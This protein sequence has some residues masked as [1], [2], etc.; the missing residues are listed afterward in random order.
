MVDYMGSAICML[1]PPRLVT[2]SFTQSP[3]HRCPQHLRVVHLFGVLNGSTKR[4]EASSSRSET[5]YPVNLL[6]LQD[7]SK[8]QQQ[9]STSS[10]ARFD[11]T[12]THT[13]THT[14]AHTHTHTHHVAHILACLDEYF[15]LLYRR[16][17]IGWWTSYVR[18][19]TVSRPF[20]RPPLNRAATL[21]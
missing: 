10:D 14:H 17:T 18:G 16:K 4:F 9:E 12:N 6:T 1:L 15:S 3:L 13:H 2:E 5:V 20:S 7:G 11:G 8:T 21:A 19:E